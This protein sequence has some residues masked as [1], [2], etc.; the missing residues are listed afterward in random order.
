MQDCCFEKGHQCEV[1]SVVYTSLAERILLQVSNSGM[2]S[3]KYTMEIRCHILA[4]YSVLNYALNCQVWLTVGVLLA[5][6]R[7]V[8]SDPVKRM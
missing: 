2:N 7:R 6:I 1:L 3:V 5:C 4:W 8:G